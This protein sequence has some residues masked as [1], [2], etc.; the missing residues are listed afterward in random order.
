MK[1]PFMTNPVETWCADD[2]QLWASSILA[3]F[4][5]DALA[6]FKS[7]NIDGCALLKLTCQD[8]HHRLSIKDARTRKALLSALDD[9]CETQKQREMCSLAAEQLKTIEEDLS[10]RSAMNINDDE[11]EALRAWRDELRCVQLQGEATLHVGCSKSMSCVPLPPAWGGTTRGWVLA[12]QPRECIACNSKKVDTYVFTCGHI[13][14]HVCIAQLIKNASSD[15]SLWP[16]RCCRQPID[17]APIESPSSLISKILRPCEYATVAA[18]VEEMLAIE[19]MYCT[20][21]RCSHF[22]N[23]DKVASGTSKSAC[24]KCKVELCFACRSEWHPGLTCEQKRA[25]RVGAD[26]SGVLHLAERSGWRQCSRCRMMVQLAH[27][28]NHMTCRCG[29]H[30]CY[31]CGQRWLN[32]HGV[33]E[34]QCDCPLWTEAN[35]IAEERRRVEIVQH[36]ERRRVQA[37][38]RA[39]IRAALEAGECEHGHWRHRE[40][41]TYGL[42]QECSNCG[43][44]LKHYGYQCGRCYDIV[45]Q[46]CRFHRF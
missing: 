2:V 34:K 33:V 44:W 14:C 12:I 27:G 24:P 40:Y 5:T 25:S 39:E 3:G 21:P 10:I 45:C 37:P 18:R 9:L 43:Y 29:N 7:L 38:E 32:A 6:S 8:I 46:T 23:L 42:N 26:Q 35:L 41:G 22:I 15:M 30:F 36:V 13:M 20:N 4:S 16:V 1:L 31:M 17:S 11:L 28:C 19:K